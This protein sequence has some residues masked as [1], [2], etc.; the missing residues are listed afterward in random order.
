LPVASVAKT[1]TCT[2]APVGW[3]VISSVFVVVPKVC[4]SGLP[5]MLVMVTV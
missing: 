3:S 4:V 1:V 2:S 5:P